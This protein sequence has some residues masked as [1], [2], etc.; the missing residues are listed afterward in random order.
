[1]VE[2]GLSSLRWKCRKKGF[3][4]TV[5]PRQKLRNEARESI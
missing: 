3:E 4:E 1:M 2:R 5:I